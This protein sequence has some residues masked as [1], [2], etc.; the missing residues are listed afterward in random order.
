[1]KPRAHTSSL[2]ISIG[3]PW[4]IHRL[5]LP[6]TPNSNRTRVS[7]IYTKGGGQPGYTAI[8]A[9]SPDH[10]IGFSVL[11]AGKG[12]LGDRWGLRAAAGEVFVAAAEHAG[13]ENAKRN[14]AGTFSDGAGSN[15]TITVEADRP[16]IGIKSFFA[17]GVPVLPNLITP[18]FEVPEGYEVA[19]RAYPSGLESADGKAVKYRAVAELNPFLPRSQAE[20]GAGLFED[21]CISWFSAGFWQTEGG[22]ALDELL[23]EIEDGKLVS[24]NSPALGKVL[25]RV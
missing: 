25:T 15:L 3:A 6:V 14:F 23:F 11:V 20:G 21:G 5:T 9:L 16:A 10:D 8:F 13:W 4:E 24:V 1:M 19:V 18:G 12:A 17:D 2:T 7:D 22:Q